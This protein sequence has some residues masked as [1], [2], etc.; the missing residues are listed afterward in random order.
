MAQL[1]YCK[2]IVEDRCVY[3]LKEQHK[4]VIK[5]LDQIGTTSVEQA[6]L[7]MK[8]QNEKC[9]DILMK[10]RMHV[11]KNSASYLK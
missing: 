9:I 10:T 6:L 4:S 2:N 5:S 8:L 7:S 3:P 11:Y 1:N